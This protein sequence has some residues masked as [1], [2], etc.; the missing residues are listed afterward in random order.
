MIGPVYTQMLTNCSPFLALDTSVVRHFNYS[1]EFQ[2]LLDGV[3]QGRASVL[4]E[5]IQ[6]TRSKFT[7]H[8]VKPLFGP[9]PVPLEISWPEK[10]K[11]LPGIS[12]TVKKNVSTENKQV[13]YESEGGN[14]FFDGRR[15]Q[16]L[17][18]LEIK[19]RRIGYENEAYQKHN[20]DNLPGSRTHPGN[21]G[22]YPVSIAESQECAGIL[23][24]LT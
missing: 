3:L 18:Q 21:Y 15:T 19:K 6:L 11:S 1:K 2:C 17:P 9:C 22:H 5:C 4:A 24:S 20:T 12:F 10:P 14:G 13:L 7:G 16:E 8:D 23:A